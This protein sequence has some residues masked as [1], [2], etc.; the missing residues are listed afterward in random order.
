MISHIYFQSDQTYL[1]H[2]EYQL[3][4]NFQ[5]KSSVALNLNNE[6][7]Q[8]NSDRFSSFLKIEVSFVFYRD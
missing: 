8:I 7:H 6:L 1:L 5:S 2:K 4:S 3:L